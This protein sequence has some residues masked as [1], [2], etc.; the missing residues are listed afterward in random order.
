M[1]VLLVDDEA[2]IR[3]IVAGLLERYG[4]EQN[5]PVHTKALSDPVQ[6]LY[7][8]TA[9][10]HQYDMIILDVRLPRLAGDEIYNSLCHVSPEL[11]DR[12]LFITAYRGDLDNRFPGRELRVLEKPFQYQ[13]LVE[14]IEAIVKAD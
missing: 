11:L 6:G 7:E 4:A 3:K 12:V 1:N 14:Q 2:N 5:L 8:A 13:Q 10:G 9:N